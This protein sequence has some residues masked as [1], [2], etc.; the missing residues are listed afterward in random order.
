MA[1]KDPEVEPIV[2]DAFEDDLVAR[3]VERLGDQIASEIAWMSPAAKARVAQ[4]VVERLVSVVDEAVAD[5]EA[6]TKPAGAN[7][8]A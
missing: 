5:A 8:N 4:G 2:T 7:E 3:Y 6:A 1:R